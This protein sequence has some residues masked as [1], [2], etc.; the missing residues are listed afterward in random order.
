[1]NDK[2]RPGFTLIEL[3]V[4]IGIL[5]ILFSLTLPA[6]QRVRESGARVRCLNNLRQIGIALH[7]FHGTF[8]QFLPLPVVNKDK[9]DPNACLGWMALILPQMGES[10]LYEFSVQ[11]CQLDPFPLDNPPHVG[12]ATVVKSYVCPDDPRLFEPLV[13]QSR[14]LASYTSYIGIG[15]C[16]APGASFGQIGTLGYFP[17]CRL[18]QITDGTSTTLM[19]GERPPPASLQAGWWYPMFASFSNFRGPNND[20]ILGLPAPADDPCL[21]VKGT[22]GPGRLDNPCDRYHLWSLHPGG[23]NFLFADGSVRFLSYSAE[24]IMMALAS[25]EG[26]EVVEVP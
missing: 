23:A 15:G 5:G 20:L 4:V 16:H 12:M 9:A 21:I 8:G 19:V 10:P 11:A 24:P 13:D 6:I 7:A 25:R 18:S 22:F 17:G 1:M 26:G 2:R 3:V 14:I